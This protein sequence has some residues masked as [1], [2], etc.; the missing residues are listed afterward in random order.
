MHF[1]VF[2]VLLN[3]ISAMK[4]S[5]I[6]FSALLLASCSSNKV[7]NGDLEGKTFQA[8]LSINP[9]QMQDNP[10]AAMAMSMMANMKAQLIFKDA[11]KG[12][13][14]AEMGMMTSNQPFDWTLESDTLKIA[15]TKGSAIKPGNYFIQ[16]T[17]DGFSLKSDSVT[18]TLTKQ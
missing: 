13:Y 5:L 12:D 7:S 2:F 14:K 6:L 11:G 9:A 10:M 16:P 8:K 15:S 4:Q 18:V 1:F 17:E 3:P